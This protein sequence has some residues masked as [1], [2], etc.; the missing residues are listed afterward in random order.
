[1]RYILIATGKFLEV[2]KDREK[3]IAGYAR[4]RVLLKFRAYIPGFFQIQK[5]PAGRVVAL[6][7]IWLRGIPL[8][9][10]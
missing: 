7:G 4:W 6:F 9:P 1:V 2:G 5:L 3:L 8:A 10:P